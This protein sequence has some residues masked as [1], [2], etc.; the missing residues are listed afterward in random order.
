VKKKE[1]KQR[2]QPKLNSV[3]YTATPK[4]PKNQINLK[5]RKKVKNVLNQDGMKSITEFSSDLK[6]AVHIYSRD[7]CYCCQTN[8]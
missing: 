3:S 5:Y 4:K 1:Q 7:I 8:Y 2:N 6:T